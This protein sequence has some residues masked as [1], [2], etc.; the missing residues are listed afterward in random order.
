M[1][2]KLPRRGLTK[3]RRNCQNLLYV[4]SLNILVMDTMHSSSVMG[5]ERKARLDHSQILRASCKILDLQP[6][7]IPYTCT[8]FFS[9]KPSLPALTS[10]C[11]FSKPL[12]Y[13]P[14]PD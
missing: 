13:L 8:T 14:N 5:W 12:D 7:T 6:K 4:F 1:V 11:T 10:W 3:R 2:K 9:S